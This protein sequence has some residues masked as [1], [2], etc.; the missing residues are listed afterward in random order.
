MADEAPW[1]LLIN[2]GLES[3]N[4]TPGSTVDPNFQK[5]VDASSPKEAE[6]LPLPSPMQINYLNSRQES[7]IGPDVAMESAQLHEKFN[8]WMRVSAVYVCA[9]YQRLQEFITP[10]IQSPTPTVQFGWQS[11]GQSDFIRPPALHWVTDYGIVFSPIHGTYMLR[12]ETADMLFALNRLIKTAIRRGT[13]TEIF[14]AMMGE[15]FSSG[16]T[17]TLSAVVA[18]SAGFLRYVQSF[19]SDYDFI[20]NRLIPR[21]LSSEQTGDWHLQQKGMEIIFGP[22]DFAARK[23][24]LYH[25][26]A[27]VCGI[28]EFQY[29]DTSQLSLPFGGSG[30][31]ASMVSPYRNVVGQPEAGGQSVS[32]HAAG[33]SS[34]P[35]NGIGAFPL[36]F[37]APEDLSEA[38]ALVQNRFLSERAH[39]YGLEFECTGMPQVQIGDYIDMVAAPEVP[40]QVQGPFWVASLR[41][42]IRAGNL[43]SHLRAD[44]GETFVLGDSFQPLA[45]LDPNT[46]PG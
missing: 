34:M 20:C 26:R 15:S 31:R 28:G 46:V 42:T 38:A 8:E 43:V 13:V 14:A 11:V 39:M 19:Q 18:E 27:Q 37:T 4:L 2:G 12:L 41:H 23:P 25:L 9:S 24:T 45:V 10:I 21:A 17:G 35:A 29:H 16:A 6:L 44:R 30:V 1:K 7:L 22:L 3:G 5:F 33:P 36:Q 40:L 32:S